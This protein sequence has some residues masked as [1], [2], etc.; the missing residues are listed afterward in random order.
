M[1]GIMNAGWNEAMR[2]A[3]E[4]GFAVAHGPFQAG[5]RNAADSASLAALWWHFQIAYVLLIAL[6]FAARFGRDQIARKLRP[7]SVEYPPGPRVTVPQGFSILE[8]SRWANISHTSIC[9]GRARCSTC[10][11]RIL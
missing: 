4:P 11:V 7:V 6:V 8:A 9:G 1:L 3:L 2:A 10:R 5:S